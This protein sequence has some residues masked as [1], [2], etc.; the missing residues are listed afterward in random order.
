L[1]ASI[2]LANGEDTGNH[3]KRPHSMPLNKLAHDWGDVF[4]L[5]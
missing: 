3:K 1:Q 2:I 5:L 4:V